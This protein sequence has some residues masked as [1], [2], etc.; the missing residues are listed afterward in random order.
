[1]TFNNVSANIGSI[2]DFSRL[3]GQSGVF[4]RLLGQNSRTLS[5]A[6]AMD[7]QCGRG[8]Y[9][10]IRSLPNV[11]PPE[12]TARYI[13]AYDGV[14]AE[15]GI[16]RGDA[17][18]SQSVAAV[19]SETAAL[20]RR[21][22]PSVNDSIEKNFVIKLLFRLD[23]VFEQ[24]KPAPGVKLVCENIT[25]LRDYLFFCAAVKLGVNV[26]LLQ[27][28]ADI[29]AR[30]ESLRASQRVNIGAFAPLT[31]P[32]FVRPAA[33]PEAANTSQNT[34]SFSE[35]D[36]IRVV[37]PE[38]K[39]KR[40]SQAGARG[41]TAGMRVS[42]A[43]SVGAFAAQRSPQETRTLQA[44]PTSALPDDVT[45]KQAPD[46]NAAAG[47]N[48]DKRETESAYKERTQSAAVP[49]A[50]NTAN[51]AGE[52]N[53]KVTIS[54]A[55]IERPKNT[56]FTPI[57]RPQ[58]IS[59]TQIQRSQNVSYVPIR[60]PNEVQR[61]EK[62]YEELAMLAKSVVQVF[63][64]RSAAD[65]RPNG[66]FKV[67]GTGSGVMIGSDGY[68]LTN[69]HIVTHGRVFAIRIEDDDNVY[70]TDRL[71]KYHDRYDLALLKIDRKLT[72]LPL[73][74][75]R[76]SLARGQKVVAIGSP[77]GLFNTVSD[78]MIS[79]FRRSGSME[80]IQFTAPISRGSSGGA[81]LNMYGELIGISTAGLDGD[82]GTAQNI[83]FAV[84]YDIINLFTSGQA[85]T[86]KT[87]I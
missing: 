48:V 52:S 53:R 19:C 77:E 45:F 18:L 42:P 70:F 25:K 49:N 82:D 26:L 41:N 10:R 31:L 64:I 12:E 9:I 20:L 47:L 11:M 21:C 39:R 43:G 74:N 27:T 28:S 55:K 61:E 50:P 4:V 76:K 32:P 5:D 66:D 30:A 87:R 81:L 62:S 58:E 57:N 71:V 23:K 69:Y 56:A 40:K 67:C 51:P 37:L 80:M 86:G 17:A 75:G 46:S 7:S 2:E 78:G 15:I 73:Y 3:M 14:S 36:M 85:A 60:R 29:D 79:G 44:I 54:R 63:V 1:M 65:I 6:A 8:A 24:V 38:R 84:K 22:D 35:G 16:T 33:L 68:I 83:N 34:A 59:Y 72:P 13:A